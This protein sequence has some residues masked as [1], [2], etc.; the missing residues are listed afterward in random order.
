MTDFHCFWN[1][2][3]DKTLIF[4]LYLFLLGFAAINECN[5]WA[6][7]F[8]T[9]PDRFLPAWLFFCSLFNSLPS[10][11]P[12]IFYLIFLKFLIIEPSLFCLLADLLTIFFQLMVSIQPFCFPIFRLVFF[13]FP[14]I[15]NIKYTDTQQFVLLQHNINI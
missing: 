2:W 6:L 3:L 4:L 5:F 10:L 9:Y 1:I 12:F 15:Y 13:F 14:S 11:F 8:K 7:L